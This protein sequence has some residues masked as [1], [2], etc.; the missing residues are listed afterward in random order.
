MKK[1]TSYRSFTIATLSYDF[2]VIRQIE[3]SHKSSKSL[4]RYPLS[5]K[6]IM[7]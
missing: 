7:I 1:T 5:E 6:E 2:D 3:R 4:Y